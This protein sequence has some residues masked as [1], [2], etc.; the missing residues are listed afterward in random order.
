MTTNGT[1]KFD[2]LALGE[3]SAT[4]MGPTLSL[5]CK[6]AFVHS[7]SGMTHAWTSSEGPWSSP[8][9]DALKELRR[10]MEEDLAAVHFEGAAGP[11]SS[12]RSGDLPIG[13][14]GEHLA[15]DGTQV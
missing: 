11:T 8:T 10:C 6:A 9:I 13:G 14:I 7:K 2:A 15:E 4:L 3:L 12:G 5:K 1:P